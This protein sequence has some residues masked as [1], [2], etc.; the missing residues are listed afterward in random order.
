ML[1]LA[2]IQV[3]LENVIIYGKGNP[4]IDIWYGNAA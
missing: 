1:W 4:F 3:T 2:I